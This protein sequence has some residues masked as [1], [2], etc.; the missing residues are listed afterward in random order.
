MIQNILNFD[1]NE[2]DTIYNNYIEEVAA[3]VSLSTGNELEGKMFCITGKLQHYKNRDTLKAFIE[4]KGG[5]VTGSVTKNTNYLINN[6]TGST[7]AKNQ[8]AI[9]LNIPIINE[10]EFLTLVTPP[11]EKIEPSYLAS[12][13]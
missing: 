11:N 3:P 13:T 7:S 12:A 2:A 10:D 6:D 5:K 4:S 9:K 8:S 1:Y